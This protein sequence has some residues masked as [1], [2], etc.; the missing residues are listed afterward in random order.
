MLKNSTSSLSGTGSKWQVEASKALKQD[1]QEQTDKKHGKKEKE[2]KKPIVYKQAIQTQVDA[3]PKIS[4]YL[5]IIHLT[6]LLI[7]PK[8]VNK[9]KP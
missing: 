6:V 3:K 2:Q 8:D 5:C 7:F 1:T 9:P 4:K